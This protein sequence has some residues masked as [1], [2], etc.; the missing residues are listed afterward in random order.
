MLGCC[1]DRLMLQRLAQQ[2]KAEA[3]A[4]AIESQK[5][6]KKTLVSSSLFWLITLL[7]WFASGFYAYNCD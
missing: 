5:I 4:E 6:F 2:K 7:L 1:Y 3:E